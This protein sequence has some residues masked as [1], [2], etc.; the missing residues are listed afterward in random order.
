MGDYIPGAPPQHV[1]QIKR[2]TTDPGRFR[3]LY[4]LVLLL[5][6]KEKLIAR[7]ARVLYSPSHVRTRGVALEQ[8]I[9]GY[10]CLLYVGTR[11]WAQKREVDL[12]QDIRGYMWLLY[13]GTRLWAQKREV[14]LKQDIGVTTGQGC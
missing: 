8:D 12:E 3:L 6:S 10:M 14:D 1:S 5:L 7:I 11:L 13:V 4:L 9:R 2:E